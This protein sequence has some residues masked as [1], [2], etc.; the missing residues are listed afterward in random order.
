M[1]INVELFQEFGLGFC[2][3][4]WDDEEGFF[5]QR[6]LSLCINVLFMCVDVD[7]VV[8]PVVAVKP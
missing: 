8:G 5:K 2:L 6:K 1:T 7:W 4:F 3:F